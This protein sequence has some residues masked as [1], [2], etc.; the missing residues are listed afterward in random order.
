[1]LHF[2]Y[3]SLMMTSIKVLMSILLKFCLSFN[4]VNMCVYLIHR[5]GGMCVCLIKLA[6]TE[7]LRASFSINLLI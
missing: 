5:G 7:F 3:I 1:M 4:I 2:S 6:P